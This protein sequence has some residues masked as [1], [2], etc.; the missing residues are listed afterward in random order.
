MSENKENKKGITER[1]EEAKR[2][3]ESLDRRQFLR[4]AYEPALSRVKETV[5]D[6]LSNREIFVV[7]NHE[8]IEGSWRKK[9]FFRRLDPESIPD[10]ILWVREEMIGKGDV[11]LRFMD[12]FDAATYLYNEA[13]VKSET[14]A[15]YEKSKGLRRLVTADIEHEGLDLL[16]MDELSEYFTEEKILSLLAENPHYRKTASRMLRQRNQEAA[17]R[18]AVLDSIP[19][20]YPELYPIARSMKRR[21]H[22]HIG[23]TNS[24]KTYSAVRAMREAESGIY[25]APLRLLAYEQFEA[26]NMDGYPC[27]LLTGEEAQEIPFARYQA[28]TVEMMRPDRFWDVAVIDEAQMVEDD[29]RGGAWTAAILGVAA[30]DVHVCASGNAE[31]VLIKLIE[32]CGDTWDVTYHER[33]TPLV[34]EDFDFSF[35]KSIEKGDALIVFSRRNVH[36]V[37]S[38]LQARKVKCSVIYGALPYDV[39]HKEA[40]KFASGE[41]DVLIAT[42]AIGMGLNLPIKRVVFLE[43]TKFDG[44]DR[45]Y[46]RASEVKQIAGRAGR[47]GIFDIGYVNA[48]GGRRFIEGLL[49]EELEEIEEAMIDFPE[50]LID[51]D[52]PLSEI[53]EKWVMT[54]VK[55]GYNLAVTEIEIELARWLE[56]YTDDKHLI[57][58]LVTIPFSERDDDLLELWQKL[59]LW[60]ID[61]ME[62][63]LPELSDEIPYRVSTPAELDEAEHAYARQDLLYQFARHF[64]PDRLPL[65]RDQKQHLS[66][67][68]ITFLG[69]QRLPSKKC[70][71]CGR[72]M[73]WNYPYRICDHCFRRTRGHAPILRLQGEEQE[74]TEGKRRRH[75]GGRKHKK[76]D[77][78]SPS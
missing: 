46:L 19:A 47:R 30:Y 34:V 31:K 12:S 64:A 36:A 42:D 52:A 67:M 3:Y 73:K 45:R 40:E 37:A 13:V 18:R 43:T 39:R 24:G 20:T 56:K 69:S 70:P 57:Y 35:P 22:L 38:E 49:G 4:D 54:P 8:A 15:P 14:F 74:V 55:D 17:L 21:F 61:G 26:L 6:R 58:E 25:L 50:T 63:E 1:F 33:Q 9:K 71:R 72:A 65:I 53:M 32:S 76:K 10:F 59:S 5:I 62:G 78:S 11:F 23:P 29:S 28:S 7:G 66:D 41:S 68:I 27:D 2:F 44:H 51:I 77:G 75:R 48:D 16:L 60:R